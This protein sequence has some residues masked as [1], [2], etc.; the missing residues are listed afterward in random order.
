IEDEGVGMGPEAL[1]RAF[2]PFFTTKEKGRG[3]GLGLSMV[4]GFVKQS[5]GHVAIDSAPGVGTKVTISLPCAKGAPA[6]HLVRSEETDT[7]SGDERVLV[8]EDDDAARVTASEMIAGLGYRVAAVGSYAEAAAALS[9][10]TFDLVFTDL[11]LPAGKTGLEV[12]AE[13]RRRQSGI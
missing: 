7:P 4:Y 6:E 13:A 8:V 10:A 5:G 1:T 9:A 3:S 11:A 2:E 12:A